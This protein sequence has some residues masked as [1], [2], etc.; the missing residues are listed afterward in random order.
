MSHKAILARFPNSRFEPE[1][2]LDNW[3]NTHDWVA[4]ESDGE[5]IVWLDQGYGLLALTKGE[6]LCGQVG[7]YFIQDNKGKVT[8][9]DR[10]YY[11]VSKYIWK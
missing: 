1:I 10:D 11:G 9:L 7:K 2:N 6:E 4:V 3:N 5:Y 8:V